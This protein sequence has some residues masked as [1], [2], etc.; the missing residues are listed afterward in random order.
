MW[1]DIGL[2]DWL[3]DLDVPGDVARIAA[4]VLTIA[5]DPLA[6]RAKANQARD[7]VRSTQDANFHV[8]GEALRR[9]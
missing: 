1:R 2:G 3:F 5:R 9:L 6:A 7:V 4:T 8:L